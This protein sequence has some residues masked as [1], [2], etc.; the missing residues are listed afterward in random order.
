VRFLREA[1]VDFTGER[2]PILV[3]VYGCM[4][5]PFMSIPARARRVRQLLIGG[6]IVQ[7]AV[8][9]IHSLFF[10]FIMTG[11]LL[12]DSTNSFKVLDPGSG[13]LRESGTLISANTFS[14]F[15]VLGL[16]LIAAQA[17]RPQVR[18]TLR[19][20][21]VVALLWWGIALSGSRY[22]IGV[23]AM[24]TGY[25]IAKSAPRW[26]APL[27]LPIAI[28]IFLATPTAAN[29][30]ERFAH[31]ATGG[32]GDVLATGTNLVL[33]STT[34][35]LAGATLED[36]LAAHTDEGQIISDNSYLEMILTY[37]LPVALLL[38]LV[39]GWVWSDL[40]AMD[41]WVLATAL[42][43]AGQFAVTNALY[44]DPYILCAGATML[45]V[46]AIPGVHSR[47]RRRRAPVPLDTGRQLT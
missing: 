19:T 9:V 20:I 29:M 14:G 3:F 47:E 39:I 21:P 42:V 46:D 7:A 26:A 40:V 41:G 17:T 10:P 30:R 35:L 44:W 12:E 28:A 1:Q 33:Q 24:I 34:N 2:F 8:G 25:W 22:A 43:I 32:R 36:Q 6:C 5:L 45:A 37:G 16:L 13:A 38:I 23:A 4:T 18:F 31:E 27:L 11:V 15:L